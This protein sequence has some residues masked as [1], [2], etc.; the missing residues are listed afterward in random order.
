MWLQKACAKGADGVCEVG[1]AGGAAGARSGVRNFD[2]VATA[3]GV[4]SKTAEAAA[5]GTYKTRVRPG[6]AL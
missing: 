6:G 3:S 2:T 5:C 4:T 1:A